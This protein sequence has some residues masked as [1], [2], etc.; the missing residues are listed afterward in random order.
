MGP[1]ATNQSAV[2][3]TLCSLWC[4]PEDI[5]CLVH[6]GAR[7]LRLQLF[8]LLHLSFWVLNQSASAS[9]ESSSMPRSLRGCHVTPELKR[10]PYTSVLLEILFHFALETLYEWAGSAKTLP[11]PAMRDT[12]SSSQK[13]R[14]WQPSNIW[15][16]IL[17]FTSVP[18][19]QPAL[20]KWKV[21]EERSNG[22]WCQ[23]HTWMLVFDVNHNSNPCL[24]NMT[25]GYR[26]PVWWFDSFMLT[27][28]STV[29]LGLWNTK[30][31]PNGTS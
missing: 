4:S 7:M 8:F 18:V 12:E 22:I 17:V 24:Y 10:Q 11:T 29:L 6:V 26:Y 31:Y 30:L 25:A 14:D 13:W 2:V 9:P 20:C 16:L 23:S 1:A 28:H 19:C 21:R 3:T 27:K 5:S 15:K